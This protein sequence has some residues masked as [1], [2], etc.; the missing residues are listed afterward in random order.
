MLADASPL[1]TERDLMEEFSASRAVIRE[2]ITAL[3]NRGLLDCRPRH[4]P[5]VRR[6]GFETIIRPP[7]QLSAS[8]FATQKG[9]RTFTKRAFLWSAA[10]SGM[11]L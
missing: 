4:R 10:W 6:A 2:A 9:S 8:F 11:R 5:I 3:S 7:A 1:P